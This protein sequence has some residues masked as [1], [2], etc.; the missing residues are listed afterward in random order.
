MV[1]STNENAGKL[2]PGVLADGDNKNIL[3]GS[4]GG[5][6]HPSINVS[7]APLTTAPHCVM[8][9]A[10]KIFALLS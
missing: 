4:L 5:G 8:K 1:V 10:D 6:I 7:S 2:R 9:A 3:V